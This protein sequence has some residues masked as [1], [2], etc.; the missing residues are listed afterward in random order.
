[1]AIPYNDNY[2][3]KV[4]KCEK[5]LLTNNIE[6]RYLLKVKLKNNFPDTLTIAMMNPS[7]A[8]KKYSDDT[9]N[10]VIEFVYEMNSCKQSIVRNIGFI[11]IVNIF[12]AYEPNSGKVRDKL[13]KI[14]LNSKL[15]SMQKRN[16]IAFNNAVSES[17]KVVLAWGDVPS[18]VKAKIHNHEAIMMHKLLVQH[19]LEDNTYVFKYEE[20]EQILTN[21][22]R[23]RHPS[24]NT[25]NSYVKI[26]N[27]RVSRNFLYINLK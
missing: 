25:L 11:N 13:D 9:V 23:P 5:K 14:I 20:Y 2:V 26:N 24:W 1:M 19:G 16:K 27:M 21:K 15:N 18:K 6:G 7:N 12:P 17:Q 3:E 4:V 10:K 8:D 22:K